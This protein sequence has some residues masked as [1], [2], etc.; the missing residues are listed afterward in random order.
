MGQKDPGASTWRSAGKGGLPSAVRPRLAA[1]SP[2]PVDRDPE[3][4]GEPQ[5]QEQVRR[6]QL[7]SEAHRAPTPHRLKAPTRDRSA[8]AARADPVTQMSK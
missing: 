1:A 8:N 7:V 5:G 6:V 3:D 2:V 4:P